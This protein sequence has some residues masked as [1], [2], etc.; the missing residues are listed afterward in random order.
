MQLTIEESRKLGLAETPMDWL[1]F[2]QR[3]DY[4]LIVG[5]GMSDLLGPRNRP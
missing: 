3:I 1:E 2:R 4:L 5:E